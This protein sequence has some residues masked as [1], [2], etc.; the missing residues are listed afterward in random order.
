MVVTRHMGTPVGADR[1]KG[2]MD[3]PLNEMDGMAEED[4]TSGSHQNEGPTTPDS[5]RPQPRE[6]EFEEEEDE[7]GDEDKDVK[8]MFKSMMNMMKTVE[9]EVRG[10]KS[11]VHDARNAA[12]EAKDKASQAMDVAQSTAGSV[13]KLSRT[14]EGIQEKTLKREDVQT[15]IE[16]M[17]D[18]KLLSGTANSDLLSGTANSD[19]DS[20]DALFGGFENTSRHEAEDWI[21]RKLRELRLEEPSVIYHKGD[22]FKGFLY[23]KCSTPEAVQ[24]ITKA[25]HDNTF[26]VVGKDVWCKKDLPIN[27]RTPLSFLLGLR[28]QLNQWGFSKREVK[29]IDTDLVL[30]V[31]KVPVLKATVVDNKI[32]LEWLEE[33]WRLWQELQTSSE[34]RSL[35]DVADKKLSKTFEGQAKGKG[36]KASGSA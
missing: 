35:I 21:T 8:S 31:C 3:S 4:A 2:R 34:L 28:W 14:V 26:K 5:L 6:I 27:I 30:S 18:K 19:Q 20:S 22:Q 29:V 9:T 12:N 1:K 13:E 7:E 24:K 33:T 36:K 11:E 10:L 32:T 25:F 15:M 17:I 16:E 23:A